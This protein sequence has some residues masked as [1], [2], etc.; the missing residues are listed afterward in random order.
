MEQLVRV[1]KCNADGTAQVL[2]VRQSA[3]SGD[4]HKCSGCG[5]VQEKL[6]F[7][8]KNPVGA[9]PGEL[10]TVKTASGPVLL[11]AAAVVVFSPMALSRLVFS[12]CGAVVL[13]MGIA[14][15]ISRLKQLRY[16]PKGKDN[17]IDAL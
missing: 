9:K 17:I 13:V 14:V 2:H 15:L 1:Q 16:L 8:A 10:V 11:A 12:L 3:C 4:C 7:T 6:L 5:A